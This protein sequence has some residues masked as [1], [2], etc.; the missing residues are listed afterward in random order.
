MKSLMFL[1]ILCCSLTTLPAQEPLSQ[2][3]ALKQLYNQ[4]DPAT[5]TAQWVCTKGQLIPSPY[6][7]GWPCRKEDTNVSVSVLL[8]AEV[9]E[10]KAEKIYLVASAKPASDPSGYD[11]HACDPAIGVAVF[12]WQAEHWVLQ[13]ANAATGFWGGWG[14]PPY[15]DFVT[16]GPS[17]YGLILSLD[18]EGQG[19]ASSY[20]VLLVPADKTVSNVWSI[21]DEQ[22]DYGAYDPTDKF[23]IHVKYRSTAAIKYIGSDEN[24]NDRND[25]YDIEVISRGNDMPGT[26]HRLKDENWTEIYRFSNGKYRLIQHKNYLEIKKPTKPH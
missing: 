22:D 21:E 16:V 15:V 2:D 11:C 26:S 1:L 20:K 18:N 8:M 4:Y 13:S 6:S 3:E 25:Y 23:A 9:Q 5:E 12:T 17:K 14:S 10:D 7:E 19:F 24:A